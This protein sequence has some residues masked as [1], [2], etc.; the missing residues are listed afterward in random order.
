MD[1]KI[2]FYLL[3][4]GCVDEVA[5]QR[6]WHGERPEKEQCW[7]LQPPEEAVAG[8]LDDVLFHRAEN[9]FGK[10]FVYQRLVPME[11]AGRA[12]RIVVF[13]CLLREDERRL[14]CQAACA[15]N[16]IITMEE[17]ER[18]VEA[19]LAH[20]RQ[21][22]WLW[23]EQNANEA[24]NVLLAELDA[25]VVQIHLKGREVKVLASINIIKT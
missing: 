5:W 15:A 3:A 20:I 16:Q 24:M 22:L 2:K 6:R 9:R 17:V 4:D 25:C 1:I 10:A 7:P 19:L 18:I 14:D 13:G 11:R 8:L 12:F 21:N 23:R